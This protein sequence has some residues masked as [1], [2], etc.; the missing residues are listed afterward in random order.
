MPKGT[1]NQGW[2]NCFE[3]FAANLIF[4]KDCASRICKNVLQEAGITNR[5][6]SHWL[7]STQCSNPE[8]INI[9]RDYWLNCPINRR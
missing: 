1:F 7:D 4:E 5:E 8:I 9:V 3:S 2:W 6:A